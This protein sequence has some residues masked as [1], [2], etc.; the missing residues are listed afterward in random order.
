M[1]PNGSTAPRYRAYRPQITPPPP[2]SYYRHDPRYAQGGTLSIQATTIQ[3]AQVVRRAWKD[4][5][6]RPPAGS[7]LAG[8]RRPARRRR[9]GRLPGLEAS[10]PGQSRSPGKR[11]PQRERR[12]PQPE[13]QSGRRHQRLPRRQRPDTGRARSDRRRAEGRS[14]HPGRRMVVEGANQAHQRWGKA[15]QRVDWAAALARPSNAKA[16]KQS[17]R[18]P[19]CGSSSTRRSR[20]AQTRSAGPGPSPPESG[21]RL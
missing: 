15:L 1:N 14:R 4:H 20:R 2:S 12:S 19:G 3:R 10:R 21:P 9:S 17:R 6:R 16:P 18:P 13:H 5:S 11:S 7:R 8:R